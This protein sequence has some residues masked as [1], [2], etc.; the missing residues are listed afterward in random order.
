MLEK[1]Q[2]S[3]NRNTPQSPALE[4]RLIY[5]G[6]ELEQKTLMVGWQ[7]TITKDGTFVRN[8]SVTSRLETAMDDAHAYIDGL[9]AV[10]L[11]TAS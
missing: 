8:G 11:P 6:Y 7:I 4:H 1:Q 5:R 10:P 9:F 3:E 2:G